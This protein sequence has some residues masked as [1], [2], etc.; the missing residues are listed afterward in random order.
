MAM[1]TT[2]ST[3]CASELGVLTAKI[4]FGASRSIKNSLMH[5]RLQE[6]DHLHRLIQ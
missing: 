5:L 1:E 4:S 2:F 6:L 3:P